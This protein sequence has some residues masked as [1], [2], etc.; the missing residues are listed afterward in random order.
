M[1][2]NKILK[3]FLMMPDG[4]KSS[5]ITEAMAKMEITI[6]RLQQ[7]KRVALLRTDYLE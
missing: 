7:T 1:L 5:H 3:S 6:A 2:L 4:N